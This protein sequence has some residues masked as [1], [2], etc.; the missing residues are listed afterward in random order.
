MKILLHTCCA[1]C[2]IYPL[3]R[4]RE[5]GFAVMGFF[6]R[7]NIHPFTE[8]MQREAALREYAQSMDMK[9][10][11]QQE[12]DLEGF[13]RKMVFREAER[14]RICYYERLFTTAKLAKKGE[15]DSFSS[16]LL[17]SRHQNHALI[18]DIG[19]A[20][21]KAA[22]IPFHYEDF[23]TGWETGRDKSIEMQMYRQQYCG[24]IYSEKERYYPQR[25]NP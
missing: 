9:V 14:C 23:R 15:F 20:A 18:A 25:K 6:Y 7:H 5:K 1:P 10:I 3:E 8:C 12:Y 17:F 22:G 19:A 2:T 4:L 24:C 11:Y 13:L 16:T 21:G